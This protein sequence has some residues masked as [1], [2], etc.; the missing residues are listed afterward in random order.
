MAQ[1]GDMD[2]LKQLIVELRRRHVFR[3]VAGYIVAA[4]LEATQP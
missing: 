2:H 1:G 4:W 3:V